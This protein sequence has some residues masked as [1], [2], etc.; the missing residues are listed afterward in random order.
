M[1]QA[2]SGDGQHRCLCNLVTD[3]D[4]QTTPASFK[5][6]GPCLIRGAELK[7]LDQTLSMLTLHATDPSTDPQGRSTSTGSGKDD[8][9][10]E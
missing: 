3:K 10:S 6:R 5:G 9:F 1:C 8:R 7:W 2:G 4:T